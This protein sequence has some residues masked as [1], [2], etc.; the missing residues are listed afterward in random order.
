M[1]LQGALSTADSTY[2]N[3]PVEGTFEIVGLDLVAG[4]L[5]GRLAD[6]TQIEAKVDA[7]GAMGG[8]IVRDGK[9]VGS[10]S[11]QRP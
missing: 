3:Q 10:F 1:N 9:T 11:L 7:A 8:I 6:M 5:R 4:Q 2:A